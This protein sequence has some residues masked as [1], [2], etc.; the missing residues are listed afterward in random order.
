MVMKHLFKI[1]FLFIV[2]SGLFANVQKSIIIEY[3]GEQDA[4]LDVLVIN[5]EKLGRIFDRDSRIMYDYHIVQEKTFD[6][7]V[8]FINK[9]NELFKE[10]EWLE[11]YGR[12][13]M[14]T[15]AFEICIENE[16]LKYYYLIDRQS[17]ALFF[18]RLRFLIMRIEPK[19][20]LIDELRSIYL[21]F[22]FYLEFGW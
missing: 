10:R 7:I 11:E 22:R 20:D 15:M 21:F 13:R 8:N 17:A 16:S 4:N 14:Y 1:F 18:K 5:T 9:N 19:N 2:V 12:F 6:E 3:I